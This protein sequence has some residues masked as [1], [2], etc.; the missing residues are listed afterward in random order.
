MTIFSLTDLGLLKGDV[1][2]IPEKNPQI[3][4]C[5][6]CNSYL[7]RICRYSKVGDTYI[8]QGIVICKF[9]GF[10]KV[11]QNYSDPTED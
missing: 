11:V 3:R 8:L 9:C 7:V 2:S 5:I 4:K 1:M 6:D 10:E